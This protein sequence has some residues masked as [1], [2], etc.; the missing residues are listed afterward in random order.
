MAVAIEHP[1]GSRRHERRIGGL[2]RRGVLALKGGGPAVHPGSIRHH[3]LDL[4]TEEPQAVVVRKNSAEVR[5]N[6]AEVRS[7]YFRSRCRSIL[8][9]CHCDSA[10]RRNEIASDAPS[11]PISP[12]RFP[13]ALFP[14]VGRCRVVDFAQR[15]TS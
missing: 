15:R 9:G 13:L 1:F 2:A 11:F 14:G 10:R 4:E 8:S 7:W 6:S 12:R 5:K 3:I